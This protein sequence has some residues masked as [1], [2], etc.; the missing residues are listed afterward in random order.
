MRIEEQRDLIAEL[1][2][3]SRRLTRVLEG[4]ARAATDRLKWE[5]REEESG[6]ATMET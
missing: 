4:I 5:T 2:E 6:E 3:E 1:D